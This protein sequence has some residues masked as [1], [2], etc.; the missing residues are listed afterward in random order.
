MHEVDRFL[1][2]IAG[3]TFISWILEALCLTGAALYHSGVVLN[4]SFKHPEES[5]T[6]SRLR[7]GEYVLTVQTIYLWGIWLGCLLDIGRPRT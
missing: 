2:D 7:H 1:G 3:F 5:V 4:E 6:S